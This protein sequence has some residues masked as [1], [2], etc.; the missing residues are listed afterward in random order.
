[1]RIFVL[2][3]THIS[4]ADTI[5]SSTWVDHFCSFIESQSEPE[6]W[7]FIL[8]DIIDKGTEAAYTAADSIFSYLT[9]RLNSMNAHFVFLPGNHDY[10]NK[11]LEAYTAFTQKYQEDSIPYLDFSSKHIW[12]FPLGEINCILADSVQNCDYRLPGSLNLAELENSTVSGKANIL[13][14]HH[15]LFFEDSTDHSGVVNQPKV[16]EYMRR[17]GIAFSFHSHTHTTRWFSIGDYSRS[18]GVGSIRTGISG[19]HNED[20]QFLEIQISGRQV[21]AVTNWLWRGGAEKYQQCLVFPDEHKNYPFV[22]PRKY[23]VPD[24]YIPRKVLPTRIA[25][26]DIFTRPSIKENERALI[27]VCKQFTHVLLISE[28]G[29]GKTFELQNL[30]AAA[31]DVAPH[32]LP[33]YL[34]LNIYNDEPIQEFIDIHVPEYRTANPSNLLLIFDGFDEVAHPDSFKRSLSQYSL[35]NPDT[36]ICISMRSNFL[37]ANS[38]AFADYQKYQLLELDS[39]TI[40]NVICNHQMNIE[41]FQQECAR[42]GLQNLQGNP[43]YLEQMLEIYTSDK[44]LPNQTSLMQRLVELRLSKDS[45]KFEYTVPQT[46]EDCQYEIEIALTRFSYALQLM[47]CTTISDT[48]Y[49]F[50]L[51]IEDRKRLKFSSFTIH[52]SAG[53][54]FTH[55]IFKEYFTA[56]WLARHDPAR[57]IEIISISGTHALNPNWFNIVGFLLQMSPHEHLVS[58]IIKADPLLLTRIEQ[59]DVVTDALRYHV[60][61]SQIQRIIRDNVWFRNEICTTKQLAA[62]SQSRQALALLCSNIRKPAHFRILYFCLEI[63]GYF[64]ELYGL[65]EMVTQDLM[66]CYQ[67]DS[68]RPIEKQKAIEALCTLSLFTSEITDDLV[69]RFANSQDTYERM[70]LYKYFAAS[71]EVDRHIDLLLN[72]LTLV[73]RSASL[74]KNFDLG[75]SNA[76]TD[77]LLNITHPVAVGKAIAWFGSEKSLLRGYYARKRVVQ[78]LMKEAAALFLEGNSFLLETVLQ[79]Y[80]YSSMHY[81]HNYIQAALT[82]FTDTDTFASVFLKLLA[83]GKHPLITLEDIVKFKPEA[84]ELLCNLF[85]EDALPDP[86]VFYDYT[87]RLPNGDLLSKCRDVVRKKTG[88]ELPVPDPGIDCEAIERKDIQVFFDCLFDPIRMHDLLAQLLQFYGTPH[89]TFSQFTGKYELY[90]TYPAGTYSLYHALGDYDFGEKQVSQFFDTVNWDFFFMDNVYH[91]FSSEHF[92]PNI[93]PKQKTILTEKA[94]QLVN[95]IHYCS[96]F[97]ET[98]P[99]SYSISLD[100]LW[101]TQLVS[102]LELQPPEKHYLGLLEIPHYLIPKVKSAEQKYELLDKHLSATAITHTLSSLIPNENR[103]DVLMDLFVGCSRYHINPCCDSALFFCKNQSID[104]YKRGKALE[105]LQIFHDKEFLWDHL[106]DHADD[107]F[108]HEIIRIF[109]PLRALPFSNRVKNALVHRYQQTHSHIYLRDLIIMNAPEGLEFYI[110]EAQKGN[111]IPD[112]QDKGIGELTEAISNIDDTALLPLLL[113]A[114][115]M[116]NSDGFR[117]GSFY[118]LYGSLIKAFCNCSKTNFTLVL[119]E[120]HKLKQELKGNLDVVNFCSTLQDSMLSANNISKITPVPLPT[121]RKSISQIE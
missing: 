74:R 51:N 64:S 1:M 29:M 17:L 25:D 49:Q 13:F 30:A 110:Q 68:T 88:N 46:L 26:T 59:D 34:H 98:G 41:A 10:C 82:F 96:A 71:G 83:V 18:I 116:L 89:I 86:K 73:S 11:N 117:D 50:L 58:W 90:Y 76:L 67:S 108:F 54:A 100:F 87:R 78:Y 93:S 84:N 39:R 55:N 33:A 121:V 36:R 19:E 48:D 115:R 12:S 31:C 35:V 104:A 44:R 61:E 119:Q 23:A 5:H 66:V 32:I 112:Y 56:K 38:S 118:T 113:N 75:E 95:Q 80:V 102:T 69:T 2:S 27:D 62:F 42:K 3:D 107:E 106:A 21:E 77:C 63:I 22:S 52:S 57:V 70:A 99:S 16:I 8:G 24:S 103:T 28:A 92:L 65:N 60:L 20:E 37:P 4:S 9:S 120:V 97:K 91:I 7:I 15:S 14:M 43:F 101:Y 109:H 79:F 81:E 72:G 114:A 105:C 111:S 40:Q 45:V 6:I 47:N 53:H 94:N 85:L